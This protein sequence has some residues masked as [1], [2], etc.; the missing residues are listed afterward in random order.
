MSREALECKLLIS[1][2]KIAGIVGEDERLY[3]MIPLLDECMSQLEEYGGEDVESIIFG[4]DL[5]C[6]LALEYPQT[7][8]IGIYPQAYTI[9]KIRLFKVGFF[10]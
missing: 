9:K 4:A 1:K 8:A 3:R 7:A 2:A 6:Y 5:F 10:G